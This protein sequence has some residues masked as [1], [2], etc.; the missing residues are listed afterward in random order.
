MS[1]YSTT[2]IIN[3]SVSRRVYIVGS[4]YSHYLLYII[5]AEWTAFSPGDVG[6]AETVGVPIGCF[7]FTPRIY[8]LPM[9]YITD[10]TV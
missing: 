7:R 10:S 4:F 1:V 9:T 2:P 8:S 5:I 3:E 6:D